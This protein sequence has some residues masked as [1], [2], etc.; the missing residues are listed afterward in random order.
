[1]K[2]TLKNITK[3]TLLIYAIILPWL[4]LNINLYYSKSEK[5]IFPSYWTGEA[6][7]FLYLKS[8]VT[9]IVAIALL[10]LIIVYARES[11]EKLIEVKSG[12]DKCVLICLA[13]YEIT[14]LVSFLIAK[15]KDLAIWG[16]VG[17][18]EGTFTLMS[19]GILFY[20]ASYMISK[21]LSRDELHK[22][23]RLW[24]FIEVIILIILTL[25]EI[26][27]RPIAMIAAGRQLE[28]EFVNMIS[29]TFYNST[30]LA[31]FTLIVIPVCLY[32]YFSSKNR[33]EMVF[34]GISVIISSI[35]C[36]LSRST[37]GFYMVIAEIVVMLVYAFAVQ[38]RRCAA[39]VMVLAF[40]VT[41]CIGALGG[42]SFIQGARKSATN[43]ITAIHREDYF[44]LTDIKLDNNELRLI[45]GEKELVCSVENNQIK[46]SDGNGNILDTH[47]VDETIRF[48]GDYK[49]ISINIENS[50]LVVDL[51]Y[52]GKIRFLMKNDAFYPM[53][54]DGRLVKDISGNGIDYHGMESMFSG[55]GLIW[56]NTLPI[57][58]HTIIFGH[59]AST[60]V[61]Y[62]K[63]FD[64]VGLLNGEGNVDL[65]IDKPHSWYLQMACNQ[66]VLCMLAVI[67]LIVI[68][69]IRAI[70][71]GTS[72]IAL[73][74]IIAAF[75]VFEIINDSSVTVNPL[76][77][78]VLGVACGHMVKERK[79]K[80]NIKLP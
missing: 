52:K 23:G 55:R 15:Y 60:F 10:V 57:I 20:V 77:W 40:L 66:G 5:K 69:F 31:A 13:I 28:S 62:Y 48:E 80:E 63:Q 45:S 79:G 74:I 9:C 56:Y 29:L 22:L 34:W 64:Y 6:D 3:Y 2:E 67:V 38:K 51:G 32:Y 58:K 35:V 46:F 33:Y 26:F 25:V 59:G 41:F 71:A 72:G 43:S 27:V 30:Y 78:V 17:N 14:T 73:G 39:G 75:S 8:L 50:A 44:K 19:Y 49:D 65:I 24:A 11:K 54:A 1:M 70:K 61:M 12:I 37:A 16:G 42:F 18:V 53:L 21:M 47:A 68:C 36:I 7:Q 76:F 4:T